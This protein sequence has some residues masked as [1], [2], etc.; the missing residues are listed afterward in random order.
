MISARQYR[1]IVMKRKLVYAVLV[2]VFAA[3]VG[4]AVSFWNARAATSRLRAPLPNLTL[5][6]YWSGEKIQVPAPIDLSK[7][8]FSTFKSMLWM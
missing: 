7:T 8:V 6:V 3:V 1:G 2:A 5:T 4:G